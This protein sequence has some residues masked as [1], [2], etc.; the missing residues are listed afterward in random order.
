MV[1]CIPKCT[2]FAAVQMAM[3]PRTDIPRVFLMHCGS[4]LLFSLI[5]V[6]D[7][8]RLCTHKKLELNELVFWKAM[9]IIQEFDT[10]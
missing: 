8:A 9:R 4:G 1:S 7:R 3:E 5:S 6:C 10:H 2:I